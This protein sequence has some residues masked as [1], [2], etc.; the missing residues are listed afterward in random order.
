MTVLSEATIATVIPV[1]NEQGH[2]GKCLESLIMQDF[3]AK[4]HLILVLDG[5]SSDET[6]K[7]VEQAILHSKQIDGPQIELLV[8]NGTHVSNAR[9]LALSV[10]PQTVTHL[11]ELIGHC[12]VPSDHISSRINSWKKHQAQ[13]EQ[14]KSEPLGALGVKVLSRQGQLGMFESWVEGTLS[15]PLGSGAGQFDNFKAAG[16]TKIPAFAMHSRAALEA[17][18]GWDEAFISCQDSDLSMRMIE[19]GY[20]LMRCPKTS[21]SMA[22][23]TSFLKWWK[24]GHRYGFWRTKT[25]LRHPKRISLREYAP[26]FGLL[27]SLALFFAANDYFVLPVALYGVVIITQ[28]LL[29]AITKRQFS[30]LFGI[31]LCLI[32]LHTSF[33]VGL[34][35]GLIRKG[36]A[37]SDR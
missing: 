14:E 37:A 27:L 33:S 11:I 3:P 4:D 2:I 30:L 16:P 13:I 35:D 15:S 29:S 1:L 31:P 32:M 17:V 25:V 5:G 19:Q 36:G 22:K 28:G 23:R 7:E 21:V 12:I 26:W 34:L 6:K 24:M 18:G 8:N 10:I 9:N 20:Q